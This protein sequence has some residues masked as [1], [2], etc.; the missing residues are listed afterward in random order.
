[1]AR[2]FRSAATNLSCCRLTCG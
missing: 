1:W 2:L